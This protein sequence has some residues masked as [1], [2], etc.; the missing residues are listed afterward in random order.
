MTI[1]SDVCIAEKDQTFNDIIKYSI[2]HNP[3]ATAFRYTDMPFEP[4]IADVKEAIDRALYIYEFVVS[5]I[6]QALFE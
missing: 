6:D 3:Y 4:E 1:D 5:K 2:A